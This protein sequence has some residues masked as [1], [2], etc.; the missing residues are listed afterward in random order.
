[1][2]IKTTT[3]ELPEGERFKEPVSRIRADARIGYRVSRATYLEEMA[4]RDAAH[5]TEEE[6][7][8]VDQL[9]KSYRETEDAVR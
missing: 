3:L 5:R 7:D 8:T 9:K 6:T 2:K 4:R 1:M